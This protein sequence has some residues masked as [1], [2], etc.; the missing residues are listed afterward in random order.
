M[1]LPA[2][3]RKWG[4][5]PDQESGWRFRDRHRDDVS[6]RHQCSGEGSDAQLQRWPVLERDTTEDD[7]SGEREDFGCK[8]PTSSRVVI[9]Y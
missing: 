4:S 5:Q 1:V 8:P 7:V 2:G 6:K 9:D 3:P